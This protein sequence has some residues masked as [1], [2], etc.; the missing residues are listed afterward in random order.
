MSLRVFRPPP[1]LEPYLRSIIMVE[2]PHTV[3]NK[4]IKIPDSFPV[5]FINFG[6]LL[7]WEM[8]NGASVEL[9][10]TVLVNV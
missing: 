10:R 9:P 2:E 4:R 8:D 7:I 5:I 3:F 1:S 6:A